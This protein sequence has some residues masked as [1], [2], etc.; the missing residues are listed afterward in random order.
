MDTEAEE[1]MEETNNTKELVK[2]MNVDAVA[3]LL[4]KMQIE[5]YAARSEFVDLKRIISK[6][7]QDVAELRSQANVLKAVGARGTIGG[8]GSTVHSQGE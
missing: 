4:I 5:N 8:T 6:A 7:T 1:K 2:K 3:N